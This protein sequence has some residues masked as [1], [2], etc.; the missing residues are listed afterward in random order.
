MEKNKFENEVILVGG[1][2][3][4]KS[5]IDVIESSKKYKIVGII[6]NN[7]SEN[8]IF[9]YKFLGGDEK[10]LSKSLTKKNFFITVGQISNFKI[11]QKLYKN[12]LNKGA[13]FPVVISPKSYVSRHALISSGSIIMHGAIL[14]SNS[15]IKENCIINTK[16]LI[17]HDSIIGSNCH[18]STGAIING[19]SIIGSNTFIGSGAIIYQN[20]S[21]GSNCIIQA[22]SIVTKNIS[23]GTF[24]KRQ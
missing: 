23:E 8:K 10:F 20:I 7:S 11:R 13:N 12:Y 21:I 2:G 9:G 14:N 18:I 17:E 15:K 22:G 24:F 4:C 6:D 16:A 5:C 3:H 19:G 1:G